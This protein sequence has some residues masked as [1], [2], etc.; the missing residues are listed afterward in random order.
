MWLIVWRNSKS[1]SVQNRFFVF[2]SKPIKPENFLKKN[3][4]YNIIDFMPCGSSN[5]LSSGYKVFMSS[6]T[7][8][9]LAASFCFHS[10]LPLYGMFCNLFICA[11]IPLLHH[12][13]TFEPLLL[14]SEFLKTYTRLTSIS[15]PIV[16]ILFLIFLSK[17]LSSL[18][19]NA[20]FDKAFCL[21]KLF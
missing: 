16:S 12:S 11:S 9:S 15:C 5:F 3:S 19:S 8:G 20:M 1:S 21:L 7:M 17:S 18:N 14:S 13:N 4:G 2:S 6:V 10:G